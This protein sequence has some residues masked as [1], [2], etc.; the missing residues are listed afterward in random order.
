M[1]RNIIFSFTSKTLEGYSIIGAGIC[2]KIYRKEVLKEFEKIK[3]I[4]L[5]IQDLNNSYEI[6]YLLDKKIQAIAPNYVIGLALSI[7]I[8][9]AK[10]PTGAIIGSPHNKGESADGRVEEIGQGF[11]LIALAGGPGLLIK[12]S[13]EVA[14]NIFINIVLGENRLI[15]FKLIAKELVTNKIDIAIIVTDGTG[16][17]QNGKIWTYYFGDIELLEIII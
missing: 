1:C 6:D 12:G 10:G 5:D 15:S 9:N 7:H 16:S 14:K 17:K 2:D 3:K 4:S 8:P 11:S 13:K